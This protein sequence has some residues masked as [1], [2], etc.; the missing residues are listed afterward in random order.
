MA[1]EM[2]V[3]YDAGL[4]TGSTLSVQE[5]IKR[6][7]AHIKRLMDPDSYFIGLYDPESD[8]LSLEVFVENGQNMP[9]MKISLADGW[10]SG[11][12][13]RNR[14]PLLVQDWQTDGREYEGVPRKLGADMLSYL[15]VPVIS[16][17][18]V[19]GLI[20]VQSIKP[21]AFNAHDERLLTALAAQTAMALEN[22]KLHQLAQEQAHLDSLTQVYN[23]G[24]FVELVRSAVA[25]SDRDDS[26]V[27]LIMLDIDRFKQYNDTYGHVAGD[28]VLKLVA[29][30]LKASVRAEDSVGRWGGEEFGVLLPG[31]GPLEA[32]KVARRIRRAVAELTPEDG[33]GR[34]IA[35]PTVSQGVS[36]YPF[37]SASA[38]DLIHE[39]DAALYHAKDRGRNE[40]VVCET[41]GVMKM[42]TVT[43]PLRSSEV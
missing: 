39:A 19:I 10:L 28:N 23:H 5:V 36:T 26:Q 43:T 7:G 17:S 4:H 9:K 8:S 25:A 22:A 2:S 6:T 35:N 24:H 20:T 3:L 40:L 14:R 16:E 21:L 27:S 32:K 13:I 11:R 12:I 15:G 33:Q 29:I 30:A 38:N 18:R 37:P 31:S 42:P 1:G 34:V 41:A